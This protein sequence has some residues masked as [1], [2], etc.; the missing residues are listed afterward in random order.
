MNEKHK[1]ETCWMFF[2]FNQNFVFI[3]LG[4]YFSKQLELGIFTIV[5]KGE[6]NVSSSYYIPFFTGCNGT[7]LRLHKMLSEFSLFQKYF[8]LNISEYLRS[9]K[10]REVLQ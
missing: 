3:V 9:L 8:V 4:M 2:C 10:S 1:S 6:V 5:N 7:Q